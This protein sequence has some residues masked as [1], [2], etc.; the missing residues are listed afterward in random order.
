LKILHT[1][2]WHLGRQ[3]HGQ[4]LEADH[5]AVLE[6][7]VGALKAHDPDVL[8]IAGD[9]FD[10]TSPPADAVRLFTDFIE[11]VGTESRAAIIFIAGNHDSGDRI[12][13][14]GALADRNRV[15]IR[16]PL[17]RNEPLI[18]ADAF[19]PVAISALPFC[20]EYAARESFGDAAI[21]C[22]ADVITAQVAAARLHRPPGARWV[23][24]AHAFVNDGETSESERKLSMGGVETVPPSAFEG[25]DYV[26][27]GHLHRAQ[28]AGEDHIR[29]SGSPL[30]F[31]FDEAEATKS[32]TLVTL[33][34]AGVAALETL[35]FR[36]L[37][38]V[39]VLTGAFADLLADAQA[40]PSNDFIK[41][42]LTDPG[43]VV[44]AMGRIRGH[45]PNAL[46][47]AYARDDSPSAN[48]AAGPL[49]ARLTDPAAVV[50]EFFLAVRPDQPLTD[51]ERAVV[52]GGFDRVQVA[53]AAI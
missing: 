47:L 24:V 36:P 8:I 39:R 45:Y 6:Q 52:A 17:G 21:A 9:I 51:A 7:V 25:A 42:V 40:A 27:L 28:R 20:N 46:A 22:P 5:V 1:S 44:D 14:I 15:L 50:D 23:I 26:A 41:L 34:A 38:G 2:D 49:G 12:G 29:Y 16:G 18:L 10:R 33:G 32:M 13:S 4:S 11:R 43:A 48:P 31:G 53:E 35:P 19:G 3:F 37:R 30:A